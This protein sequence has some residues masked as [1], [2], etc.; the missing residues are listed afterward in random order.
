MDFTLQFLLWLK[1]PFLV[2]GFIWF[3]GHATS[4]PKIE[5]FGRRPT[6]WYGTLMGWLYFHL[7]VWVTIAMTFDI[8]LPTPNEDQ[9]IHYFF[10]TTSAIAYTWILVSLKRRGVI[11]FK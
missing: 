4:S 1:S 11:S 5:T 6:K 2:T 9:S 7:V 8:R 3:V 10:M